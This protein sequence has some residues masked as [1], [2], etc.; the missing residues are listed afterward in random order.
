MKSRFFGSGLIALAAFLAHSGAQAVVNVSSDGSDGAFNPAANVTVNLSQAVNAAWNANNAPNAGKGVYD[1]GKWAV[2]FKYSSVNIPAGV[3]VKFQNHPSGAPVVWLVQG[4]VTIAGTLD[5]RG[6]VGEHLGVATPGGPGG[7]RGG[8]GGGT[9]IPASAGFGPGG[10]AGASGSYGTVGYNNSAGSVYGNISLVPLIGGSGAAG[11]SDLR[12]GG[13]GGGVI[14]IA[15]GGTVSLN[16]A[17]NAKGGDSASLGGSGG[18]VRVV[19]DQLIGTGSILATGGYYGGAKGR[20]RVEANTAALGGSVDPVPS[21]VVPIGSDPVLWPAANAP[22]IAITQVGGT[23][24]P[25]DPRA[26]ITLGTQDVTLS[27]STPIT[28]RIQANNVPIT[29]TMQVRVIPTSG[30]DTVVAATRVSGD[31]T[32]SIWEATITLTHGI[33]AL[34]ARAIKP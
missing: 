5:L 14:L 13:G 3:T 27:S 18:G 15:A 33:A 20:I 2:V 6:A 16:G 26:G 10:E 8:I 30:A 12:D 9:G 29:W 28:V 34:Q 21:T 1:A 23:A 4:N 32:A 22:R 17:I 24:A 11:G 7:F 25:A 19:C 31:E